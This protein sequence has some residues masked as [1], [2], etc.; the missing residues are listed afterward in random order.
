MMMSNVDYNTFPEK[1]SLH[2]HST[3]NSSRLLRPPIPPELND[4][5]CY[6]CPWEMLQPLPVM[7]GF[8][9]DLVNQIYLKLLTVKVSTLIQC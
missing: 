6:E 8:V 1:L 3:E 9:Y 4:L 7:G 2:L 5:P